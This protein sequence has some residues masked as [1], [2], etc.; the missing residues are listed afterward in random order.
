MKKLATT[1]KSYDFLSLCVMLLLC[2]YPL[3]MGVQV[4][5]AS[6]RVGYVNALDYP[7]YVIPYTP[8]AL[9]L[10][11]SV[12]LLP[13]AVRLCKRFTLPVVSGLGVG[14]FL[15]FE[16]LFEQVTVFS[17]REGTADLG[18]WQAYL[19]YV[20][21]EAMETIE[22]RET[23]GE[24][25]AMRYSAAFKVH[26]YLIA[27]LI[28]LAVIGVVYGFGKMVRDRN[29]DKKKPLVIQT[30]AVG[31]FVCLCILACFTAFYRTGELNI[32]ALSSWLMSVF[33]IVFGLTAG[34]Y[35]GSLMYF[36]KPL[37]S[38]I[39][40]AFIAAATT[41]VM[42]IGEL[43]LMGGVL[44]VFGEGFIFTPLGACPVAPVDLFVI[45]LSGVVTYLTLFAIRKPARPKLAPKFAD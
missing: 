15:G 16:A 35:S 6:I 44:F 18:S 23:V 36:K 43:V 20:T 39:I 26:F 22:Y 9:A 33:F 2:F 12:M 41:L 4:L 17:L 40:P 8:I 21:P 10:V 30:A 3:L 7:K 31:M 14:L 25:L 24:A 5:A 45:A 27:I 28:V 42:Y 38:R 13:L 37:F 1:N 11:L 29:F 19:C 32:S 34:V